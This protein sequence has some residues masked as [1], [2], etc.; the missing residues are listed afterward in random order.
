ML[1]LDAILVTGSVLAFAAWAALSAYVL[2]VDRW[3]TGAHA[4]LGAAL[5]TLAREDV[6]GL[7]VTDQVARVRPL[8]DRLSPEMLLHAAAN[9]ANQTVFDVLVGYLPRRRSVDQLVRDASAHATAREKSRRTA[10]LRILFRLNHPGWTDLAARAVDDPDVDV[11]SVGASLIG[12]SDDPHA[13]DVMVKA[14][15]EERHPASQLAVHLE[16]SPLWTVDTVRPLLRAEEPVVRAWGAS[17]MGR[18]RQEEG[19]EHELGLLCHDPDAGVRKAAI[20]SLG[21]VG[22]RI[23]SQ[24]ARRLLNDPVAYVRA[25]AALA[26]AE[27]DRPDMAATV[28]VL[29]GDPDWWV[30]Q[31]AKE[32]LERMGPDAWPALFRCLDHSD[33][34][35]RNGAAE[36]IQNLGVLDML[37]VMEGAT[38]LP[39]AGKIDMLRRLFAAGGVRLTDSLL[40][41]V[42]P[43]VGS[44]TRELLAKLELE[45]VEVC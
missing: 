31:A 30:R 4:A 38:D 35:V 2:A 43:L 17:V 28:A 23:A 44:R 45:H 26:L 16:S 21:R 15:R 7:P 14:L 39:S 12:M 42:G 25:H 33:R 41:R 8:L 3:R 11:A 27:L 19:L 10:A 32:S 13:I 9:G 6:R 40:E 5:E 34:F 36:V 1:S 29:L 22:N 18:Y 20:Q 37:I 24:A